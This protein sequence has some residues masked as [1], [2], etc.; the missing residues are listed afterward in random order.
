MPKSQP[1]CK[2]GNFYVTGKVTREQAANA[3]L[4]VIPIP[5][6]NSKPKLTPEQR[7]ERMRFGLAK[8]Q[9]DESKAKAAR[10][11][12]RNAILRAQAKLQTQI[13]A[14]KP[15][16]SIAATRR[17]IFELQGRG[18]AIS[19]RGF[20]FTPLQR[21]KVTNPLALGRAPRGAIV[22]LQ[23]DFDFGT[24][25]SLIGGTNTNSNTPV[26]TPEEVD[27]ERTAAPKRSRGFDE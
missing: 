9:S 19:D 25:R 22:P 3:G 15:P 1:V 11:R 8:A 18:R 13:L 17:R 24:G 10:S 16:R 20:G 5:R 23:D 6:V 12:R 26:G 7:E 14:N 27:F 4:T 21:G 2:L